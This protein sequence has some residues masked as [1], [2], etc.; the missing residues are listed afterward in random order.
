[1]ITFAKIMA[2]S[3]SKVV[4]AYFVENNA[5]TEAGQR[6]AGYYVGSGGRGAWRADMPR[7]VAEALGVDPGL[8]P[9]DQ[10]LENLFKARR[11]D[12]EEAWSRQLRKLSAFDFCFGLP[13]SATLA[14]EFAETPAEKQMLLTAAERANH[15][16]MRFIAADLCWA[17]RGKGGEEGADP[18]QG[19][20]WTV[21]H[22]QS[23]PTLQVRDGAD[24]ITYL[25]QLAAPGDPH[26]HFHNPFWNLCVTADGRVGSLDT[27]RLTATR[28]QLYGAYAQA[29]LAE[30]IRGVGADVSV[31]PSGRFMTLPA[32]PEKAV[33]LFSKA[34][35]QTK[36]NAR[37]SAERLGLDWDSLSAEKKFEFLHKAAKSERIS[38]AARTGLKEEGL[39]P[40]EVWRLQAEAIGWQHRSVLG[41]GGATPALTDEQRLE[42][43]Y[44][45]AAKHISKEFRTKAVL[46]HDWLAI[47]AAR[48]L[49]EPGVKGPGDVH[50]VVRML[51]E[52]G[53]TFNGK[54]A[55][56][57]AAVVDG[58]VRVANSGQVALERRV[59]ALSTDAAA[60]KSRALPAEAFSAA[61]ARSGRDWNADAHSR[62]QAA[63]GY[64]LA[65]GGAVTYLTGVAGSGKSTLLQPLVDAYREDGR[66]VFGCATGW[67]QADAMK[68]AGIE[69]TWAVDPLLKAIASG[70][71]KPDANAVLV[72][73]EVS[74]VGPTEFLKLLELQQQTGFQ[75][76]CIGDAEQC[77]AVTAGSTVEI[78]ARTLPA[79]DRPEIRST[80]RQKTPHLQRIAGLFRDGEAAIAL[81]LKRQDG[82]A[83]MLGGD[84]EQV[85]EGIADFMIARRDVLLAA[86]FK[87]GVGCSALTNADAAAI[88]RAV[89]EKLKARGEISDD[90]VIY[91][92]QD[93]RGEQYDLPL[94]AGDRA[95]LYRKTW[96]L[97]DGEPGWVGSNGDVLTVQ[98]VLPDGL[99]VRDRDGRAGTVQWHRLQAPGTD[100]LLLGPGWC[101]TVDAIQGATLDEH[102]N[103]LPRGTAGLSKYKGYV[104]ESR[105]EWNT[106]TL[107]GEAGVFETVRQGK[108]LGDEAPI[109]SQDL[110]DRVAKD[111]AYAE[112][113]RLALDVVEAARQGADDALT[114]LLEIE[115]AI[116]TGRAAGHDFGDE[117]QERLRAEALRRFNLTRSI[118][119]DRT[120]PA[121]AAVPERPAT[122]S[123]AA[124]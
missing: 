4:R 29:V 46:D 94:A 21:R 25:A 64:A 49:I 63:A 59:A 98:A 48:G 30:E 56:L 70:E 112:P 14:I 78:L 17:R 76:K 36:R 110:W 123:L 33:E 71:F 50:R 104:A 5:G 37:K 113:R 26:T 119:S 32:I 45:F 103:A 91:R 75:L 57:Y 2:A 69:K 61:L 65:T 18:A 96:G 82:T 89:R 121:A 20:W 84:H 122:V 60:D 52:R 116:E 77:Q 74:Q 9:R 105:A 99:A 106:W 42:K 8:K 41:S 31:D 6:L 117:H 111:F 1:M 83:R 80:V 88:S 44:A 51:E 54:P 47:W 55:Q 101:Q 93:Q 102:I 67:L 28:V 12:G 40:R 92:A 27:K 124:H 43:A 10:E 35:R 87:K 114:R 24:G 3:S 90:E 100:R 11:A 66:Q 73:E 68:A 72:V 97:V 86:G 39:T 16:M 38:K 15:R 81:D 23:R 13:K 22:D 19:G 120:A 108:A 107:V 34:D 79:A 53:I 85:V 118:P 7:A 109:A 58:R 95:R 115:R 62:A